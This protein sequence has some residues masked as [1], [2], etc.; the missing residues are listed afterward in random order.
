MAVIVRD[1]RQSDVEAAVAVWQQANTAR[2]G[3]TPAP[4]THEARVRG[5]LASSDSFLSVAQDGA[6]LVG[7]ALGMQ[8]L[9]QDG[10][11]PP[12]PGLCH[13]SMVFVHPDRWGH[14]IGRMLLQH[15]LAEARV[16]TYTRCQLWTHADNERAQKLYEGLGF[17]RSGRE[18]DDDMGDR[19]VHFQ[20]PSL[21]SAP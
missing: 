14:G 12:L 8:G 6:D 13:I 15:L 1:G 5:Y 7:M 16:R 18:I 4:E 3:G 21:K 10:K 17:R 11:G 20:L 19:I 2:R 9:D